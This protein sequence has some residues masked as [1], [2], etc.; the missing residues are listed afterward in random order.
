MWLFLS[1][2]TCLSLWVGLYIKTSGFF[3]S[4]AP[5]SWVR[6]K[7][8]RRR[9]QSEEA[10]APVKWLYHGETCAGRRPHLRT[11]WQAAEAIKIEAL[12]LA[13]RALLI[14]TRGSGHSH[15]HTLTHSP[16]LL[17]YLNWHVATWM[18]TCVHLHIQAN[19][20][21]CLCLSRRFHLPK[22]TNP[23]LVRK[24][25]EREE[26]PGQTGT[27]EVNKLL[28]L[29]HLALKCE[30]DSLLWDVQERTWHLN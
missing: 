3:S 14:Q 7:R 10:Q 4:L 9:G 8:R 17:W 28:S 5:L 20:S 23:C 16:P 11:E 29:P 2:I 13:A 15:P 18:Q 26:T 24:N 30:A 22:S 27:A 19:L 21:P 1:L 6:W 12:S 25:E